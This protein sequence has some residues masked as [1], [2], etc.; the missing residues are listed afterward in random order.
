[1]LSRVK[2]N[3]KTRFSLPARHGAGLLASLVLALTGLGLGNPSSAAAAGASSG[4][5]AVAP[6]APH[7]IVRPVAGQV[8]SRTLRRGDHGEDVKTLQT[9][10][11]DLG[12]RVAVDG[13]FG[14]ITQVAVKRFQRQAALRPVTGVVG[15]IT[16]RRLKRMVIRQARAAKL[17]TAAPPAASGAVAPATGTPNTWVFPLRPLSAILPPSDWTLD[18]GIDIGTGNDVCGT[19]VIEVAITDGTIVQEGISGFGPDAPI[20]KVAS[21]AYAR[22]YIYYGHAAPAL[23][24]VGDQVTAGEPIAEVGCGDVGISTAPHLEIGI[25]DPGGPTCCPGYQETSPAFLGVIEDLYHRAG[26]H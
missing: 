17:R 12:Q 19:K 6:S 15:T 22:R 13:L 26:G 25:S 1:M 8:F 18:Q 21:G 11:A 4:G 16:A 3:R 5:A 20:L 9:W 7:G 2:T 10:L 24:A 14:P 23:V